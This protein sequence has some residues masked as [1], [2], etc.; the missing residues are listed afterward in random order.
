MLSVKWKNKIYDLLVKCQRLEEKVRFWSLLYREG[1]V[2]F[3][4]GFLFLLSF[5]IMFLF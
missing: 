3:M 1:L 4:L 5:Q 2:G